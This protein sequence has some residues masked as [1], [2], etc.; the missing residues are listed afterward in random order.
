MNDVG[1]PEKL[2]AAAIHGMGRRNLIVRA[3]LRDA[4]VA[5]LSSRDPM[6][7]VA[8]V[9]ALR[10]VPSAGA[11]LKRL[12]VDEAAPSPAREKARQVLKLAR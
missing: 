2:R 8:A 9:V 10:H 1:L 3:D 7:A 4:I 12:S 6:V 11:A 5:Q